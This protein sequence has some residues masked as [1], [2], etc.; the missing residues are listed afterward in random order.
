MAKTDEASAVT[1]A[2][3][4]FDV[5]CSVAGC[6]FFSGGWATAEL[7]EARYNQHLEEHETGEPMPELVEF[8]RAMGLREDKES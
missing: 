2:D 1:E 5:E 8:E 6:H 4:L 7:A 3:E